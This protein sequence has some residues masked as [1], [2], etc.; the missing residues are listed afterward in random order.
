MSELN[1]LVVDDYPIIRHGLRTLLETRAGWKICSEAATGHAAVRKVR[2]LKPEIVVLDLGLPD[3]HG[4]EV[5]PKILEV[6]PP[7][8]ILALT[9]QEHRNIASQ[10]LAT[11][12][13]G[14]VY[15][16]DGL[17]DVIRGVQALARGRSF[18]SARVG[19]ATEEVIASGTEFGD[20]RN[21]LTARELQI[22]KLLAEGI[23]NKQIAAGLELS[24]RT[25]EAHRASL[26]RK[27]NLHSLSD[28]IYFAIRQKIVR[29]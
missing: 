9:E 27:L 29:I 7:A 22:L 10:A 8:G 5:I 17:R 28:L 1:I 15:K 11:G 18:H 14:L 26:M 21:T 4:L 19:Q 2:R 12:A 13:R 25:V 16:S 6:H 24:I 20:A 3:I 23:T